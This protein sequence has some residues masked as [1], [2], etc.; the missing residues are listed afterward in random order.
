MKKLAEL[1]LT[2]AEKLNVKSVDQMQKVKEHST[3]VMRDVTL[4]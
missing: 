1:N 3:D 2:I 4:K